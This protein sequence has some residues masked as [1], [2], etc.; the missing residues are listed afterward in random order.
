[1]PA[2]LYQ[3]TEPTGDGEEISAGT[4]EATYR[5]Q[6][7][8]KW[9]VVGSVR[10]GVLAARIRNSKISLPERMCSVTVDVH[11]TIEEDKAR[12]L[13]MRSGE[14]RQ[15]YVIVMREVGL[16]LKDAMA[17]AARI[18]ASRRK[19]E[20]VSDLGGQAASESDRTDGMRDRDG[21]DRRQ[22]ARGH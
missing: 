21:F 19:H 3:E 8:S 11:S 7:A 22:N 18:T 2:Y 14:F 10:G 13:Y 15:E 4:A 16:L 1:M 5:P 20:R 9:Q 12:G 17:M 6:I